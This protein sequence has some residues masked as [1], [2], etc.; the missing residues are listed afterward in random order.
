MDDYFAA[1][2][3]PDMDSAMNDFAELVRLLLGPTAV[4]A[5]K[6]MCGMP[7]RILGI[8]V[9]SFSIGMTCKPGAEKI[10]RWNGMITHALRWK[11]LPAGIA[12]K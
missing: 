1:V 8:D 12:S 11:T 4:S 6:L 10:Q 7:L 5:G 3:A 9:S 2:H